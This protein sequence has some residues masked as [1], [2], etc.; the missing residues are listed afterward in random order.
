MKEDYT[1][2]K[3]HEEGSSN[4]LGCGVRLILKGPEEH[5]VQLEYTLYFKFKLSNN[6]AKKE[7]LIMGLKLAKEVGV[8]RLKVFSDSQLVVN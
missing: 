7:A 8:K 3:L 1:C 4:P 5:H 6:E 2:W